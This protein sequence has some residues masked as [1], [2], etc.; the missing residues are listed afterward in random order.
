MPDTNAQQGQVVE[1]GRRKEVVGEVVSDRMLK[2]IVVEVVRKKSH[3]FYGRVVSKVK[4]FY[5]HDEK[6]EAHVGDVVRL[7]ETRPL[8]KLKRWRLKKILRR[9]ALLPE[10]AATEVR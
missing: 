7:E 3:P 10:T 9:A 4:K 6:N 2:T 5:A 1:Q 8:S